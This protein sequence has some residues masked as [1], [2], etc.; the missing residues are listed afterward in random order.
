[1]CA[2]S[3]SSNQTVILLGLFDPE[4]DGTDVSKRRKLLAERHSEPSPR[5]ARNIQ[6][7][8][9]DQCSPCQV[10]QTNVL[11][12]TGVKVGTGVGRVGRGGELRER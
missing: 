4:N 7:H 12:A 9:C 1:V 8:R 6:H 3:G 2:S 10:R 5:N 11:L